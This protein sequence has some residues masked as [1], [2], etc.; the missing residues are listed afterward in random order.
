MI[1]RE[2][3]NRGVVFT[4]E[5]NISVYLI[6]ADNRLFLCDTHLGPISMECIKKY[7]SS[8]VNNKEIIIFNSHSDWD[9][10]WG[11]CAFR[12]AVIIAHE[13][14]RKRMHE[15]GGFDL[16]RLTEFHNGTIDLKLP[17]LTFSNKIRFEEDEVE[18]IYAP[19][20]TIDS[21]VCLDGK[22]SVLFVGDLVEHPIP[23][24]DYYDLEVY[25]KTLKFIRDFPARVKISSHSG[26]VDNSL[27]DSNIEYIGDILSGNPVDPKTYKE[28]RSVHNFNV[29]NRLLLKYENMAREK[30]GGNFDYKAFRCGFD[31]WENIEYGALKE[32]LESYTI[33]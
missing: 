11:N 25:I 16:E 27:I 4:F 7:I 6:K 33:L 14:C 1:I 22:D 8:Q 3:G 23:Y 32:A 18:F 9:H 2:I 24:L 20:H 10:I 28:C 19:G 12:D 30:S 17:N 26:T 21:A 15:I 5:D 13:T 31:G 29:N